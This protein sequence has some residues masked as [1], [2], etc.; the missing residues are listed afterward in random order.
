[1]EHTG[2]PDHSYFEQ[3]PFGKID[4]SKTQFVAMKDLPDPADNEYLQSE[5]RFDRALYKKAHRG[6]VA[7]N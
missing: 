1:M 7:S 2:V 6:I 4:Y 3:F 5:D